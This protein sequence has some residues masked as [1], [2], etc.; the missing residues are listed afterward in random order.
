[1]KRSALTLLAVLSAATP[2]LAADGPKL[3]GNSGDW[4]AAAYGAGDAKAC[5]AFTK[6]Q[7]STPALAK[8]G[9]VQLTV[10]ERKGDRDEVTITAGYTYPKNAKVQ[11]AVGDTKFDFYTQGDTAFTQDGAKVVNALEAGASA[12]S[13][14][15]GPG[16][17]VIVDNFS[18]AGFSDA[19]KAI[20]QACP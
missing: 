8:R 11:L 10:T 19:Y 12:S 15:T 7:N 1:M 6:A 16:G 20:S 9:A 17:H 3:L 14:G 2:A 13:H 5:Y 4:T 18:L